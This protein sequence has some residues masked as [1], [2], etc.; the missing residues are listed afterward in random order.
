MLNSQRI[1]SFLFDK[2]SRGNRED[3]IITKIKREPK[4]TGIC[5]LILSVERTTFR[6]KENASIWD[7][8]SFDYEFGYIYKKE[9]G[10]FR[11]LEKWRISDYQYD[12]FRELFPED[13]DPGKWKRTDV[14]EV[15]QIKFLFEAK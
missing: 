4:R 15:D 7:F 1:R 13:F 9:G 6:D 10:N 12:V 8:C 2:I 3:G 14:Q 5:R 11:L